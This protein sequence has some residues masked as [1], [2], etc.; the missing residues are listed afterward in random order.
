MLGI[1]VVFTCVC[2]CVYGVHY[3]A[4]I[5]CCLGAERRRAAMIVLFAVFVLLVVLYKVVHIFYINYF[6][7]QYCLQLVLV[8]L[9]LCYVPYYHY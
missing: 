8:R 5:W 3:M 2:V 4:T 9:C 1:G 6:V 7:S